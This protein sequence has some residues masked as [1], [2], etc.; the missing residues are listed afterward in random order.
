MKLRSTVLSALV[1]LL[2][3]AA[4]AQANT[5]Q[6]AFQGDLNALDP[7]ALNEAFTLGVMGN[8]YEALTA[9]D[10]DMK[11]VPGLAERWEVVDPLKW[12]FHLR[13]GVK[14][15][16]GEAFTA[17]D[18]VFSLDRMRTPGSQ[19]KTRAPA[20]M[21][22]IKVDDHTVDFVTTQPNPILHAEWN[23]WYIFSKSWA[24]ANGATKAQ[25]ASATSLDPFALK[26][27]GTGPFIIQSHEPGIKTVFKPNPNYWGKTQHNL[28]EVILNTIKQGATRVAALLS[29]GVDVIDPVPLQD[30]ER[31]NAS[32]RAKVVAGPELRA[33]FLNMDIMRDELLYSSVKGRNP[34][35]DVRVRKAFYQAIDIETIKTKV[36]RGNSVPSAL[37]IAA[38]LF[39][40]TAEFKRWPYDVDAAKALMAQAGFA[41]GFDLTMD[42]PNDRY[43]NDEAICQ[44]VAAMLAKIGVKITLQATPKAKYFEKV[45]APNFDTSFSMLGWTAGGLDSLNVLVNVIGCRDAKGTGGSFNIGGYCNPKITELTGKIRSETDLSKR[46]DNIAEAYRIAHEEVALL[47]LHQ[48]SLSWGLATN[49]N[50]PQRADGFFLFKFATKGK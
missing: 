48:Q 23:T 22:A 43:V 47:P 39:S 17:D 5:L 25:S 2:T 28:D 31:V 41:E 10:N 36:M 11:I 18:V 33:I 37:P 24:E 13:R 29:G 3:A 6:L 27:N 9:R 35:K 42:C 16:N 46:D 14:F 34:F 12:R 44:A 38:S 40:R 8:V 49:V 45:S 1:A 26:A 7:Y 32:G 30:Q 50:L 21:K 20:D 4:P 15:H 19:I